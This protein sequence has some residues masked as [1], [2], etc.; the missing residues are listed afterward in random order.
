MIVAVTG[1]TGFIGKRLIKRLAA[2][3]DVVR[4]L[5]R[6][7]AMAFT[8]PYLEVCEC[9][10]LT[11]SVDELKEILQ[12]VGV[13]FHCAGQLNDERAMKSLHVDATHKL[14]EAAL[15][16]I[17]HWVQLSSVGVYGPKVTG[18]VDEEFA[19][20]PRGEYETTK[21]EADRLVLDAVRKGNFSATILRPSNVYGVGMTNLSLYSLISMI[22]NGLFFFIG[23]PGAS[24]N[25]IHVENVVDAL[26]LCAMNPKAV[27]MTYNI[28]DQRSLEQFVTIIA[29]ALG[30]TKPFFR[31]PEW[32]VRM[33]T[34]ATG[35]IPRFPLNA[36]RVDAMTVRATYSTAKIEHDLGY[37]HRISMEDGLRELTGDWLKECCRSWP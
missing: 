21:T 29:T 17:G 31:L 27:G 4:V 33:L 35:C 3:G 7:P 18:K 20:A 26:L 8:Q 14:I 34:R 5:S 10:L 2:R 13:L 15:G 1:G 16:R 23:K 19:L 37:A 12:G 32:S 28:S 6:R 22:E 24:A 11:A 30:R 9:D 36:K 25:Y